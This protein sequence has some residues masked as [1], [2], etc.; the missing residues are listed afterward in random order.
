[1]QPIITI[2]FPILPCK[3]HMYVQRSTESEPREAIIHVS[4]PQC[5]GFVIPVEPRV[6]PL[7]LTIIRPAGPGLGLGPWKFVNSI[8]GSI[9]F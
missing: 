5:K 9:R 6:Q 1:M 7:I 3:A 2:V 4:I 8:E